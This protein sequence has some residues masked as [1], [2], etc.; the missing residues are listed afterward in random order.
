MWW[1][2]TSISEEAAASI[3]PIIDGLHC[4]IYS[5]G[6]LNTFESKILK[7]IYGPAHEEGWNGIPD[8]IMNSTTY[9]TQCLAHCISK[10]ED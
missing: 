9:P 7:R 8:G 3:D 5:W 6:V 2:I 10:L 1:K 4:T